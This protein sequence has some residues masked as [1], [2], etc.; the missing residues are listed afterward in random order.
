MQSFLRQEIINLNSEIAR[1]SEENTFYRGLMAPNENAS[2]LTLGAVE[3]VAAGEP[4]HYAYS[5]I[6]KQLATRHSVMSGSLKFTVHGRENGVDKSYSLK[7]LSSA[8]S[9]DALKFRFKY[10]Q[11]LDG[12][13][14]LPL[15][16]EPKG[17][18]IE[19]RSSGNSPQQVTKKFGWLIEEK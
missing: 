15:G 9:A 4:R 8:V 17:I 7:D 18:E 10:F 3:L 12:Q 6:V 19:A 13:L 11:V 16:F 2:G 1:L 5:V 14:V